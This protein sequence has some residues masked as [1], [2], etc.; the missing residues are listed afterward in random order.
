MEISPSTLIAAAIVFAATNIDDV[1]I[2]ATFFSDPRIKRRAV[3]IGQFIGIGALTAVSAG[4]GYLALTVPPGWTSLLGILPLAIGIYKFIELRK[5]HKAD[6]NDGSN[7]VESGSERRGK[8]SGQIASV[9]VVTVA[10]GGDNLGVYIPLFASDTSIIPS[11]VASFMVLTGLWCLLGFLLVKN[12]AGATIAS[13]WGHI[14]LPVVLIVIG[15]HI[16]WGARVLL[17]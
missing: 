5:N 4:A 10:N 13:R 17:R 9:T 16:L 2:L 12:P 14:V 15:A 8:L 7:S 6:E 11:Y 1:V 3:V